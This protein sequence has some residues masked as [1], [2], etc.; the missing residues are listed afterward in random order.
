MDKITSLK[1][2]FY[3]IL[4]SLIIYSVY[5]LY[6]SFKFKEE[7]NSIINNN[8]II[9]IRNIAEISEHLLRIHSFYLSLSAVNVSI[10]GQTNSI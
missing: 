6:A 7:I 9:F 8:N 3:L 5:W 4:L 2:I 1:K 10:K